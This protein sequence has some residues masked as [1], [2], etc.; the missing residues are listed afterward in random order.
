MP[1]RPRSA[2][3]LGMALVAAHVVVAQ[4]SPLRSIAPDVATGTS[5]AVVV[6][7]STASAHTVQI[8]PRFGTS[9]GKV[10][11]PIQA[12][13]QVQEVLDTLQQV[14]REA[15]SGLDRLVKLDVYVAR[16]EVIAAFRGALAR[17]M[18]GKSGPAISFVLGALAYPRALVALDAVAA[19]PLQP[20][21]TR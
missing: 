10:M 12:D 7:A 11:G 19:T 3:V 15:N 2:L 4:E 6:D 1:A 16:T 9:G 14:L 18:V 21:G 17:R 20:R 8:Y 5:A 13:Q